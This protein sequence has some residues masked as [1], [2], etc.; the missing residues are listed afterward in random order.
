MGGAS[1][2]SAASPSRGLVG[3]AFIDGD[4][5]HGFTIRW[6]RGEPYAY[7]LAGKRMHDHAT[8]GPQVLA[9]IPVVAAGWSEH[10]QIRELG[11]RWVRAY[12]EPR[13]A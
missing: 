7:V 11:M 13:R 4:R 8:E 5:H 9:A 2:R 10:K 12:T 3:W 1:T 6:A